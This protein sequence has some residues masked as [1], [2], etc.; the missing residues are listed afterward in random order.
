MGGG[1]RRGIDFSDWKWLPPP[2]GKALIAIVFV[3]D[4]FWL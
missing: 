3:V 2:A 4:A 1:W